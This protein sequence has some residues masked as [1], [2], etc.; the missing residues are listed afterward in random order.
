MHRV[1]LALLL[2]SLP[3]LC[4]AQK[5]VEVWSYHS[6]PPFALP[7]APGLSSAFVELLNQHASNAGRFQFKLVELP[8]KRL[9]MR[10]IE[11]QPGVLLWS[12]PEFLSEAQAAHASWS[13]PLLHDQQ[14][15]ISLA[16]TPHDY[17]GADSLRGLTLGGILGHRY[18]GLDSAIESGLI[19]REDVHSDLQNLQ[20]LRAG[21]VDMALLPRSTLLYYRKTDPQQDLYV[22]AK[23]LH[24]FERR[25]L[26]TS[27]LADAVKSYLQEVTEALSNSPHW[28][29][30]LDRYGLQPIAAQHRALR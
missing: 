4:V 8:R 14:D 1:V 17:Q 12:T 9:D 29:A 11:N 23:P 10:L 7:D 27:S 6:S 20:K 30:L 18:K 2:G 22:S 25:L 13:S 15:V 3:L 21:R 26:M 24:R 19:R 28:H 16:A 5:P